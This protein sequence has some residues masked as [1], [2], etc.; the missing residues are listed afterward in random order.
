MQQTKNIFNLV[1]PATVYFNLPDSGNLQN[2]QQIKEI[3]ANIG[4][5]TQLKYILEETLEG[6][7]GKLFSMFFNFS[8]Q[9]KQLFKNRSLFFHEYGLFLGI[10][11]LKYISNTK[12]NY[13][14]KIKRSC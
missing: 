5:T 4:I 6:S 12:Q 7:A 3:M 10:K 8:E 11:F 13:Y 1:R 14:F 2:F 9:W